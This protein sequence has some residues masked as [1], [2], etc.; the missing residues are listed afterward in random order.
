M[1]A[2]LHIITLWSPPSLSE[3]SLHRS[4]DYS[5]MQLKKG[6][7]SLSVMCDV[8]VNF[9]HGWHLGVNRTHRCQHKSC[10]DRHTAPQSS[11]S[12]FSLWSCSV[13]SS[14]RSHRSTLCSPAQWWTCSLSSIRASKSSANWSVPT[15]RSSATTWRDSPRWLSPFTECLHLISH[16]N[17]IYISHCN[18]ALI[19]LSC[20][21]LLDHRQCPAVLCWHYCEGLSKSCQ[22]GE[23]GRC[24]RCFEGEDITVCIDIKKEKFGTT[25]H[26]MEICVGGINSGDWFNSLIWVLFLRWTQ[27]GVCGQVD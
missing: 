16:S 26:Q 7:V 13:F 17:V 6:S 11:F 27:F 22:E 9:S 12:H 3:G 21:F 8:A 24:L 25:R 4:F 15:L 14:S 18:C 1:R 10:S 20:F 19:P 23:S 5:R 2:Q